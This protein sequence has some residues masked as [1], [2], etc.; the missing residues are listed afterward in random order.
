MNAVK[1]KD[2]KIKY[3]LDELLDQCSPKDFALNEEDKAWINVDPVGNEI[4]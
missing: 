2:T 3:D 1:K 4:F